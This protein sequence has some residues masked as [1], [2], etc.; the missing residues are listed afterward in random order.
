M[1]VDVYLDV[2]AV[3]TRAPSD[4]VNLSWHLGPGIVAAW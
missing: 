2:V 4:D 3:E 1:V